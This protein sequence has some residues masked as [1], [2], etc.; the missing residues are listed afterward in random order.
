[1]LVL[2][3]LVACAA[4]GVAWSEGFVE[5]SWVAKVDMGP[6]WGEHYLTALY[7][8][9]YTLEPLNLPCSH[10]TLALA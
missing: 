5:K 3:H 6:T 7:W 8:S 9:A 10:I 4:Y 1:M 2:V